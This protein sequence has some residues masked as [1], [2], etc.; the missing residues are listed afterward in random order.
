MLDTLPQEDRDFLTQH[1]RQLKSDGNPNPLIPNDLDL[2]GDGI[3]DAFG[4]D[5]N[6]DLVFVSGVSLV[7]TVYQSDGD[8]V[9]YG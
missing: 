1:L 9:R 5:E 4:L 8:D 6:N 7:D 3:A 2:D